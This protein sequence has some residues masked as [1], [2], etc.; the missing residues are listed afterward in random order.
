MHFIEPRVD[1]NIIQQISIKFDKTQ[2]LSTKFNHQILTQMLNIVAVHSG[3]CMKRGNKGI[4]DKTEK[5]VKFKLK[6]K[7]KY[8]NHMFTR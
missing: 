1:H 8:I 6:I 5:K 2:Q 7:D 3:L 4:K